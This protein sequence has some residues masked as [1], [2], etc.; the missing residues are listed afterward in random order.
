MGPLILKKFYSYN[1]ERNLAG[2]ITAWYGKRTV[3]D[4]KAPKR[5]VW[6]A[7]YITGLSSMPSRTSISGGVGGRPENFPKTSATQAIDC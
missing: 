7:Q 3:L 1:I 4:C 6:T 2:C 5:V